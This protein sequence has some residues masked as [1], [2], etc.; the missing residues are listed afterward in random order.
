[1]HT[2]GFSLP[3][4]SFKEEERERQ[5]ERNEK[6]A[7]ENVILLKSFR[8]HLKLPKRVQ[9]HQQSNSQ[10][11]TYSTKFP[12]KFSTDTEIWMLLIV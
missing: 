7:K 12:S 9:Y 2:P 6:E 1:M 10:I 3:Q 4:T 5:R 11:P 8:S